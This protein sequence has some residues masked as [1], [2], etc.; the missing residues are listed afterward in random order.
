MKTQRLSKHEVQRPKE[1]RWE[2][3]LSYV[4]DLGMDHLVTQRF[5]QGGGA[6]KMKKCQF[7]IYKENEISNSSL[8]F[9]L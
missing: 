3:F 4:Q 8:I 5:F 2:S 9:N 1:G 7:F 6:R